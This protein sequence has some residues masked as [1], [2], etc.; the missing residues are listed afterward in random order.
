MSQRLT[1]RIGFTNNSEFLAIKKGEMFIIEKNAFQLM[2]CFGIKKVE[3]Q[4]TARI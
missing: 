2:G 3:H 4:D 1:P